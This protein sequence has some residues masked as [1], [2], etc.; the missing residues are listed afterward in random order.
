MK[1]AMAKEEK[2]RINEVQEELGKE[3]RE[4]FKKQ[5]TLMEQMGKEVEETV[6]V[7]AGSIVDPLIDSIVKKYDSERVSAYLQQ[8]RD[9]TL[10]NLEKFKEDSQQ[11]QQNLPFPM[12]M[13]RAAEA[14]RFLEYKV[15]LVVDNAETGAAP[16]LVED[17][18]TYRNLFGT[19]ERVVDETGKL[20][21]YKNLR[22]IN[23]L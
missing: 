16:V 11:Q 6:K 9:H 13:L 4:M 17:G 12:A 20:A 10:E 14:E 18:P 22:T 19:I 23:N 8:I 3:A 21:G 2:E 15:N 1:L 5:K 7:Y